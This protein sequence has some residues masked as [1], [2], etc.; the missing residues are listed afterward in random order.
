MLK[1]ASLLKEMMKH[2]KN[3]IRSPKTN[4]KTSPNRNIFKNL[5]K[6]P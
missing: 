6:T 4:C 5:K 1:K 3:H 2:M